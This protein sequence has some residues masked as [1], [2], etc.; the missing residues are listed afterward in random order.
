VFEIGSLLLSS[1][2]FCRFQLILFLS[3]FEDLAFCPTA[4]LDAFAERVTKNPDALGLKDVL[5]ILK[6][7]S[8]LNHNLQGYREP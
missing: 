8:S 2:V 6:T 3:A 5:S 1:N 4:M 7:Y